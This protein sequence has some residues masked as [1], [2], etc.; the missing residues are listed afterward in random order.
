MKQSNRCHFAL[1][2]KPVQIRSV[3]AQ[4]LRSH[5]FRELSW[6][7]G[8]RKGEQC[9][10]KKKKISCDDQ[11]TLRRH[12]S[13]L[14]HPNVE[15]S[16]RTGNEATSRGI[17]RDNEAVSIIIV[18]REQRTERRIKFRTIYRRSGLESRALGDNRC[19]SS[20]GIIIEH[21]SSVFELVLQRRVQQRFSR[22][23]Q[24]GL[25]TIRRYLGWAL[26]RAARRSAR[27]RG[28]SRASE[29]NVS[30]QRESI[31][32]FSDAR[33]GSPNSTV[34]SVYTFDAEFS[35]LKKITREP[36]RNRA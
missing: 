7:H 35:Q 13:S 32:V 20:T 8:I 6:K 1:I 17:I 27:G 33:S 3:Q 16:G 5:R 18:E 24:G 15:L 34:A 21:F 2:K 28:L 26:R 25:F 12:G 30:R 36:C 23:R 14:T 4:S 19:S 31:N 29:Y 22:A 10:S 11:F 9:V